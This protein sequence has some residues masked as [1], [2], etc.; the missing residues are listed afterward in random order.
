MAKKNVTRRLAT[1]LAT[2]TAKAVDIAHKAIRHAPA[3]SL[4]PDSDLGARL[5]TIEVGRSPPDRIERALA[6][7]ANAAV[8]MRPH[9]RRA[10]HLAGAFAERRR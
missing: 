9:R 6:S 8:D 4:D 5:V 1:V 10:S 3:S 2:S 7:G